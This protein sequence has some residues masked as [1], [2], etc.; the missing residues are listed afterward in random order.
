MIMKIILNNFFMFIELY[1]MIKGNYCCW[2]TVVYNKRK[3]DFFEKCCWIR[4]IQENLFQ[5]STLPGSV[6]RILLFYF[7]D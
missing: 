1:K 7:S 5:M 4:F 6:N 3:N 2:S